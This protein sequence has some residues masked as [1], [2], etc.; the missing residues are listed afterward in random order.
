MTSNFCSICIENNKNNFITLECSHSFH[1]T[2]LN[3]WLEKHKNC[4]LCRAK[5]NHKKTWYDY[6]FNNY[7]FIL[8]EN[9]EIVF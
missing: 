6:F 7:F 1:T 8:D 4:P 2:C 9:I 5:I 3:L